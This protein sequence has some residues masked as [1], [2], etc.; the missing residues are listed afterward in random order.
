VSNGGGGRNWR[1][2][3]ADTDAV[4]SSVRRF[5]ARARQRR[6]RA[7]L[8]WAV[9]LGVLLVL[10]GLTWLIYGT[11][12]LGVRDVRVVGTELLT[13]QQV[14]Q[15]I[16]VPDHEP[17]ARVDLDHVRARVRAI[18]AVDRVVV[19][20]SWP[21]TL[22]VEVVE[23]TPVAAVPSGR[24]FTLIDRSGVPYRQVGAKP[25][26]LPLMRLATPGPAD[27]DTRSGLT[28]LGAL[29][30][31]LRQQLVAV[32]VA[33]PAQ[34]KLELRQDRTVVWGDDTQSDTK[35]QVATALLKR[36]ASEIDVSAP[37]V[38]TIR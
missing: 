10:G 25:A 32:S 23:R 14:R 38:V 37:T 1:L 36:A 26:D 29:S 3:R 18:P 8:P 22:V 17:L 2:V 34:I 24:Q 16:G 19:R 31:Q 4:P 5:M 7:A 28:V 33:A 9:G 11:P 21:S 27:E 6:L 15:A 35:S 20:R 13:P 12:V 30:S